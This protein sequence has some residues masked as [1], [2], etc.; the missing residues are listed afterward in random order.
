MT[1]FELF[2][3]LVYVF[4]LTQITEY[5]VNSTGRRNTLISEVCDVAHGGLEFEDQRC[6][7]GSAS[8][9]AR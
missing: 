9:V 6:S 3:D 4:A 7:G 2:F 5:M 8:A 1:T